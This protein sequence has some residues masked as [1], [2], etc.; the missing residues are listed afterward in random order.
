MSIVSAYK[1]MQMG[2]ATPAMQVRMC[3][4]KR[5]RTE[6]AGVYNSIERVGWGTD[7]DAIVR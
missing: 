3:K 1:K 6:V 4:W 2:I 5:R 7:R